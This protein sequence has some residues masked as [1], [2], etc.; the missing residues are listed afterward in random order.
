MFGVALHAESL[1]FDQDRP[2]AAACLRRRFLRRFIDSQYI[3]A[4]HD[5]RRD[6]VGFGAVGDILDPHAF[7]FGVE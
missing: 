7:E 4:V 5:L 6:A 3:V 1:G 2:F